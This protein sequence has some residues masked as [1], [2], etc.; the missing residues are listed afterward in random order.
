[1]LSVGQ[2]AEPDEVTPYVFKHFLPDSKYLN[3]DDSIVLDLESYNHNAQVRMVQTYN[4]KEKLITVFLHGDVLNEADIKLRFELEQDGYSFSVVRCGSELDL[5]Q[6]VSNYIISHKKPIIG[7]NVA[8][9]DIGLLRMKLDQYGITELKF[10]SYKVGSGFSQNYICFSYSITTEEKN[11]KSGMDFILDVINS[12]AEAFADR[13]PIV[14][15]MY[16]LKGLDSPASLK[17]AAKENKYQKMEVDY[18]VFENEL[19]DY[20]AL[21]YSIADVL[22]VP[23][24]YKN[25]RKIIEPVSKYLAIETRASQLLIEHC[26]E[27]GPGADAEAYLNR[28]IKEISLN[29]PQHACKYLG[30][31]TRNWINTEIFKAEGDKKIHELDLTSAYV[32]A[33]GKQNILDILNGDVK[34]IQRCEKH[35][36][37]IELY[38]KLIDSAVLDI[39]LKTKGLVMIEVEREKNDKR[40]NNPDEVTVV[41]DEGRV[42]NGRHWGIGYVRSF[43]GDDKI[44]DIEHDFAF[45]AAPRGKKIRI[46]KTEYEQNC[47]LYPDFRNKA[48]IVEIVDGMVPLSDIKTKEYLELFKIR[49]KLK[50]EKNP[51]QAGIK[52]V[53]LSV[54]GKLAQDTGEFFNKAC[55]AAITGFTRRE[56][57]ATIMY[58]R[59]ISASVIQSDTD[60]LY[61]Y[62]NENQVQRIQAFAEELNPLV[63]EF[64]SINLKLEDS[65]EVFWG[66]KRKR[67]IKVKDGILKVTGENGSRDVRWMD[68]LFRACAVYNP[69][70]ENRKYD[71][72]IL[73]QKIIN[74][75]CCTQPNLDRDKFEAFCKSIYEKYYL[76][77]QKDRKIS[78]I[79]P[80]KTQA[81]ITNTISFHA[82]TTTSYDAGSSQ[83]R[84]LK[85]WAVE[86][87]N[88]ILKGLRSNPQ[89]RDAVDKTLAAESLKVEEKNLES[90][91]TELDRQIK[92]NLKI[93]ESPWHRFYTLLVEHFGTDYGEAIFDSNAHVDLKYYFKKFAA[94]LKI[95]YEDAADFY[96][97]LFE[98]FKDYNVGRKELIEIIN[99]ISPEN[100]KLEADLPI[101]ELEVSR[102]TLTE[103]IEALKKDI[104]VLHAGTPDLKDIKALNFKPY[105]GLFFNAN[106]DY[107]FATKAPEDIDFT[108]NY[109]VYRLKV[110][111][112]PVIHLS[113]YDRIVMH[114]I[115]MDTIFLKASKALSMSHIAGDKDRK[116]I[117]SAL[118]NLG[119]S[120][121]VN[122]PHFK[123]GVLGIQAQLS[124]E[125]NKETDLFDIEF[126]GGKEAIQRAK[127]A[128]KINMYHDAKIFIQPINYLDFGCRIN[129][130]GMFM[131]HRNIFTLYR[132]MDRIDRSIRKKLMAELESGYKKSSGERIPGIK[133]SLP[134]LNFSVQ[135]DICQPVTRELY[136]KLHDFA[137]DTKIKHMKANEFYMFRLMQYMRLSCYNKHAS[138]TRKLETALLS[139]RQEMYFITE[140]KEDFRAEL[141]FK[142]KRNIDSTLSYAYLLSLI[143]QESLAA[144]MIQNGKFTRKRPVVKLTAQTTGMFEF[145]EKKCIILFTGKILVKTILLL[146]P[147]DM[148]GKVS[149]ETEELY[150]FLLAVLD[151]HGV[152]TVSPPPQKVRKRDNIEDNRKWSDVVLF[153]KPD[154]RD[155]IW[156]INSKLL[157]VFENDYEAIRERGFVD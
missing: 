97:H 54:Y 34:Y 21:K 92:H 146:I 103:N 149:Q 155:V 4:I 37:I 3:L 15:T 69:V 116:R 118:Y 7:H 115:P 111:Y 132:F 80:V 98:Y 137:R 6:S 85:A 57:F 121:R 63:R 13:I 147:Q 157:E 19:L 50:D 131:E 120:E 153:V 28:H 78:A 156:R 122:D 75:D 129:K 108:L 41:D 65:Y 106:R 138:A 143:D 60:S 47:V 35:D 100:V 48:I 64:D 56:L 8:H 39:K 70:A 45:I 17:E 43:S 51:S 14:D 1:M 127:E 79:L 94:E 31:L 125:P 93:T 76:L 142:L 123:F 73:K 130:V 40:P 105:I 11:D 109:N 5:I 133:I 151:G 90:Q 71:L 101:K 114:E 77:P 150:K 113:E 29:T 141:K 32:F 84:F 27:K 126:V 23:E 74:N 61:V 87:R 36:E 24:V 62:A 124:D 107:K 88:N 99:R 46:T 9:F 42:K 67:Y 136:E 58:A 95:H 148:N 33:I 38:P 25:I 81:E 55:A 119:H 22:A 128:G 135:I 96:L 140:S 102:Q 112:S 10:Q 18:H 12:S 2:E 89:Y 83:E 110:D 117:T 144:F 49:K 52:K 26:W 44:S 82:R 68:I 91:K 86:V 66:Q 145:S 20:E 104:N 72:D 30:G 53:I 152:S 59:N 134:R 154:S 139:E 16:L